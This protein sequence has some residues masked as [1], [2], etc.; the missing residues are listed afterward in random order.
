MLNVCFVR[1]EEMNIVIGYC[2]GI[3]M[4]FHYLALILMRKGGVPSTVQ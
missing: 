3:V 4:T 2:K 1:E